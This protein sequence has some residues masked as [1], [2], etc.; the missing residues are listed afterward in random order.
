MKKVLLIIALIAFMTDVNAQG[1]LLKDVDSLKYEYATV[2]HHN[3]KYY[4]ELESGK[5]IY[6]YDEYWIKVRTVS[7]A[8]AVMEA[9]GWEYVDNFTY[10][11]W[12]YFIFR[13]KR[14]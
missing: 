6:L 12:P 10:M 1:K 8:F 11:D 5:C 4:V 13:R 3:D 7:I 2:S 9:N 14:K